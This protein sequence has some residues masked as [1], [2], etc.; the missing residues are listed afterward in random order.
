MQLH[1]GGAMKP[2]LV[3]L[4]R[5]ESLGD[6]IG[7]LLGDLDTPDDLL[8][9]ARQLFFADVRVPA[10]PLEASAVIVDETLRLPLRGHRTAAGCASQKTGERLT[11]LGVLGTVRLL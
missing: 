6:R 7:N 1:H 2:L 3:G 9:Q 4:A 5:A 10:S 11:V 8:K